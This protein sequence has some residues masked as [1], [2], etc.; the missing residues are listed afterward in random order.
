MITI[1]DYGMGNL[2]S[3]ANMFRKVGIPSRIT[4][5]RNEILMAERLL[6][7]GVGAFDAAMKRLHDLDLVGVLN[8]AVFEKRTPTL[9]ICLGLQIMTKSSD[10]GDREGLGW[11]DA[12]V[13]RFS[14]DKE[15]GLKSPH[16][17]WNSVT[18]TRPTPFFNGADPQRFYFVHS[19][20]V[21]SNR[22]DDV[23][24]T[25]QHGVSFASGLQRA[26]VT[27]FQFHP[28]KSHRFGMQLFQRFSETT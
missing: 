13:K 10:E 23:L 24:T 19:Y 7:P 28:E 3:I 27:G 6:L 18:P 16:M 25:T 5:A 22:A 2:G 26:N 12:R 8:E 17:G 9:G 15:S 21:E 14:F 20:Y 1:V 4:S 11:F